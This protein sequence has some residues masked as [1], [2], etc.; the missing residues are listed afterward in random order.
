MSDVGSASASSSGSVNVTDNNTFSGAAENERKDD[1]APLWMFVKK[2]EKQPGGGCWRWQC[3]ICKLYYN[4]S[5]TRVRMHLL[6]EGGSGV[7]GC[8]KVSPQQ[9][10]HM[11]KLVKDAKERQ[12]NAAPRQVPL[13]PSRKEV[14]SSS[15]GCY[16]MYTEQPIAD[17]KKR[18]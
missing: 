18:K 8:S 13:P 2:I 16:G 6:K 7:V 4:G 14:S 15:G 17:P 9:L 11:T 12:Q 5:Y 3:N 10:A 1:R